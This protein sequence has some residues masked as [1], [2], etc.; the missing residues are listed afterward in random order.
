MHKIN[1]LLQTG[2]Q[3]KQQQRQEHHQEHRWQ[4]QKEKTKEYHRKDNW[5]SSSVFPLVSGTKMAA[6][7]TV[8]AHI[9][10]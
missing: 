2:I 4:D 3:Y 9:S 6:N 10:M 8:K 1:L 7:A 5:I